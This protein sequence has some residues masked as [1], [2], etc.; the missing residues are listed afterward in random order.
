MKEEGGGGVVRKAGLSVARSQIVKLISIIDY[1]RH[2][3]S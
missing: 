1:L 3:I 2:P